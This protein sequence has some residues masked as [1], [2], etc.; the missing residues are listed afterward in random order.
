MDFVNM[1][2]SCTS[3]NTITANHSQNLVGVNTRFLVKKR[4]NHRSWRNEKSYTFR[5]LIGMIVSWS[6]MLINYILVH[7]QRE[8][9]WTWSDSI[10]SAASSLFSSHSFKAA[11]NEDFIFNVS[12]PMSSLSLVPSNIGHRYRK[13]ISGRH[14]LSTK[15]LEAFRLIPATNEIRWKSLS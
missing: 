3:C 5:W 2:E 8:R 9:I 10:L 1:L 12:P 4:W 6:F 15:R 13:T 7:W 11:E 14:K